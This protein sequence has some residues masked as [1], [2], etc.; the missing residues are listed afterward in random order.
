[1]NAG[2]ELEEVISGALAQGHAPEILV[3]EEPA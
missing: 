3:A 2:A 1:M